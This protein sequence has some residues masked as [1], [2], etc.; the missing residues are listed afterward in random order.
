MRTLVISILFMLFSPAYSQGFRAYCETSANIAAL[1]R[2]V[3]ETAPGQYMTWTNTFRNVNGKFLIRLELFGLDYSGKKVWQKN[4]GTFNWQYSSYH[5]TNRSFFKKGQFVYLAT[6]LIDSLN[7][8]SAIL[9]KLDF[10]G[11]L[12]WQKVIEDTAQQ[13][14]PM[15]VVSSIDGGFL[16]TGMAQKGSHEHVFCLKTDS[17]GNKIWLKNY[18]LDIKS[19]Q[20]RCLLQD[21]ATGKIIFTGVLSYSGASWSDTKSMVLVTDSAGNYIS[22]KHHYSGL[23]MDMINHGKGKY[24]MVGETDWYSAFLTRKPHALLYDINNINT[25]IWQYEYG[26]EQ[27]EHGF[28]SIDQWDDSTYIVSG[29]IDTTW[30]VKSGH[31]NTNLKYSFLSE[32]GRIKKE[33]IYNYRQDTT[34]DFARTPRTVLKTSDGGWIATVS[35]SYNDTIAYYIKYDANGCDSTLNYCLTVGLKEQVK[36]GVELFP[37]PANDV[38]QVMLPEESNQVFT[39]T[40]VD[41]AGREVLQQTNLLNNHSIK[42]DALPA[43]LY[44]VKIMQ[45]GIL[46]HSAKLIK[47]D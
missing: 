11:N 28:T 19:S 38:V 23:N 7:N 47:T 37:N 46:V 3:I 12:L 36:K 8:Y 16:I 17:L 14:F 39:I 10:Q 43:G 25:P 45:G 15:R 40:L 27:L 9:V 31:A 1:N 18:L 20:A 13:L 41:V 5:F 32:N 21:S 30:L 24:L 35:N 34:I 42:I 44:L 33:L 22:M 6:T 29:F 4:Y 26:T 2:D